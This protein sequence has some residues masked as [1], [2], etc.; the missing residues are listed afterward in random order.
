MVFVGKYLISGLLLD[1]GSWT[2]TAVTQN[3]IS[4]IG[5]EL[6]S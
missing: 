1:F 5:K 2:L 3:P 6:P 4:P